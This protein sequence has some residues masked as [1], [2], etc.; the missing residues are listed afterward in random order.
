M[1]DQTTQSTPTVTVSVQQKAPPLGQKP[2]FV[3]PTE[4]LAYSRQRR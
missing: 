4:L 1:S 2:M 3:P